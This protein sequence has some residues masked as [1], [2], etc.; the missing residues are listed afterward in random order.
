[1][2]TCMHTCRGQ[3]SSSHHSI[4]YNCCYKSVLQIQMCKLLI[5]CHGYKTQYLVQ[6]VS[7]PFSTAITMATS[8][9]SRSLKVPG[10]HGLASIRC[11]C[12]SILNNFACF[13]ASFGN[14]SPSRFWKSAGVIPYSI[15]TPWGFSRSLCGG[16]TELNR[17]RLAQFIVGERHW[18]VSLVSYYTHSKLLGHPS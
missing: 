11:L 6:Y 3:S 4:V 2:C 13:P 18:P 9:Y 14:S 7:L 16:T 12:W 8:L 15:A 17:I 10:E 1:V 5:K